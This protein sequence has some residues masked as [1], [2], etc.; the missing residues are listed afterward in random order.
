MNQP[1]ST[2]LC[3]Q[4]NLYHPPLKEGQ[5]CPMSKQ[6]TVNGEEIDYGEFMSHLKNIV[7]SQIDKKEIKDPKK[8]FSELIIRF[9]EIVESYE[10]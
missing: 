8:M 5:K 10:E 7:V 1:I 6:K 4:C 3:S 2:V 9:M